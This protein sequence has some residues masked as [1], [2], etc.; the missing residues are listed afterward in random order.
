MDDQKKTKRRKLPHSV[1]VKAPGLLQMEYKVREIAEELD[2]PDRTIRDWLKGG[3]PHLRDS[4]GHYWIRGDEFAAW[5]K[6]QKK[7]K[8]KRKLSDGEAFCFRCNKVVRLVD[9]EMKKIK[10]K[11]VHFKGKCID[12]GC[13]INRGGRLGKSEELLTDKATFNIS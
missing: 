5:V 9:P 11:L 4:Q 2:T 13:K 1:I 7:S 12:C 8:S 3:A 10:G 6:A